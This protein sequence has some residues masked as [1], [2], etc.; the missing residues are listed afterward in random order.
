MQS[1]RWIAPILVVCV[2][3]LL[4]A[5]AW[6]APRQTSRPVP[7]PVVLHA[8]VDRLE[9]DRLVIQGRH[10][11]VESPPTVLLADVPLEVV[12]FSDV[13]IIAGLP[14]DA[15]P[16]RYTLQVLANGRVPSRPVEIVVE[17]RLPTVGRW[18]TGLSR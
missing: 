14:L 6:A 5:W 16:A 18:W 13:E 12:S 3:W 11:G 15:P 1:R 8:E 10:F 17:S 4:S 2:V 7:R 9:P